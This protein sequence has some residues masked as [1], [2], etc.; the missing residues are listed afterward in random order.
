MILRTRY[1]NYAFVMNCVSLVQ[2]TEEVRGHEEYV[3]VDITT[4]NVHN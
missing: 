2:L 3:V 4:K 1:F